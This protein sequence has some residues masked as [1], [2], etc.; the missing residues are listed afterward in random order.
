[1]RAVHAVFHGALV[2]HL[3]VVTTFNALELW[4]L[5]FGDVGDGG[6]F[7]FGKVTQEGPHVAVLLNDGV[8]VNACFGR[9]VALWLCRNLGAL[10]I[11]T[12]L[13]TV[14]GAHD[15]IFVIGQP[16]FGQGATAVD[17]QVAQAID[18]ALGVPEQHEVLSQCLQRQGAVNNVG[19]EFN[20]PP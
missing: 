4:V 2:V 5:K 19:T 12:E 18:L 13:P 6:T 15:G 7:F 10:T 11:A 3:P 20:G 9:N 14:V 17:T 1:M 16:T 8:G